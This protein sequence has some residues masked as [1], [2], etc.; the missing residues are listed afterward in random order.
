MDPDITFYPSW[1]IAT[2]SSGGIAETSAGVI[3]GVPFTEN[4]MRK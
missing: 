4:V 2:E 3:I 1:G